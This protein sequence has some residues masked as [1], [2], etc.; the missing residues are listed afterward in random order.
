[1]SVERQQRDIGID[2]LKCVC[3]LFVVMIHAPFRIHL[4]PYTVALAR[5]AVPIFFIITGYYFPHMEEKG[6]TSKHLRKIGL[7][8][9]ASCIFYF[10]LHVCYLNV[11]PLR[12]LQAFT[13]PKVII[14][15]FCFNA[16]PVEG[17]LWYF[18]SLMYAIPVLMLL[19][20]TGKMCTFFYLIPLMLVANYLLT[21]TGTYEYYRNWLLTSLPYM[22]IGIFIRTHREG[23]FERLPR[24][25]KLCATYLLFCFLLYLE[26]SWYYHH[27]EI[28]YRDDYLC[29]PWMA[30]CLFLI[31]I[32]PRESGTSSSPIYK[33]LRPIANA[34]ARIGRTYSPYIYI[35]HIA[36]KN[37]FHFWRHWKF[38]Y[39]VY[40]LWI[41]GF[42]LLLCATGCKLIHCFRNGI[43]KKN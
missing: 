13:T 24:T 31:A 29:T 11:H 3:A 43:K 10:L 14:N 37:S 33:A 15:F 20:R 4:A 16:C 40:P 35:F 28:A 2:V 39:A 18:F 8:A 26:W 17:H 12:Y 27:H 1:M 36:V 34:L 32:A 23:I 38:V 7:L 6:R 9:L 41:F 21:Y 19:H 42:T 30:I 5:V 22:G 25:W